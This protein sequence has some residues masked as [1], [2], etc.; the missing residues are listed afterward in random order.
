MTFVP[1]TYLQQFPKQ[2]IVNVRCKFVKK[3]TLIFSGLFNGRE[4]FK[5][6]CMAFAEVDKASI[7]FI[8]H[9]LHST[10]HFRDQSVSSGRN[11]STTHT[12]LT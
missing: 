5:R 10:Q 9:I 7:S 2:F 11:I 1:S 3:E 8:D 6:E 4:V 12:S